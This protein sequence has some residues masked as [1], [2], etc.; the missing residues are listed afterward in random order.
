MEGNAVA[1]GVGLSIWQ[2]IRLWKAEPEETQVSPIKSESGAIDGHSTNW[3][4]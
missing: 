3:H 4:Y 1:L 2:G